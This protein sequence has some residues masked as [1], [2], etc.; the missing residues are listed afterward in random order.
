MSSGI[1]VSERRS[2]LK[3]TT[4]P[5]FLAMTSGRRFLISETCRADFLIRSSTAV[6]AM[7]TTSPLEVVKAIFFSLCIFPATLWAKEVLIK[8]INMPVKARVSMEF[9]LCRIAKAALKT[10]SGL[11]ILKAKSR[12]NAAKRMKKIVLNTRPN[13][14]KTFTF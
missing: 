12:M 9:G 5:F 10:V 7:L 2:S 13:K 11:I 14:V 6:I 8:I 3:L 4:M 1:L